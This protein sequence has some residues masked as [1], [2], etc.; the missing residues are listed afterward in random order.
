[1]VHFNQMMWLV[2]IFPNFMIQLYLVFFYGRHRLGPR[3]MNFY[4]GESVSEVRRV[5]SSKKKCFNALLKLKESGY[6][7]F[8]VVVCIF[9]EEKKHW[10]LTQNNVCFNS[11][12]R[13]ELLVNLCFFCFGE[14]LLAFSARN[15]I[16]VLLF[17]FDKFCMVTLKMSSNKI[18]YN[19]PV[20][21]SLSE[22][23]IFYIRPNPLKTI[24][25][26]NIF[27]WIH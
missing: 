27:L 11:R 22:C 13:F 7:W 4:L 1:M 16:V 14:L 5:I 3:L 6:G 17:C 19:C 26:N 12:N 23:L 8:N 10:N 18:V 21:S 24:K 15:I 2:L 9:W 20:F 25:F